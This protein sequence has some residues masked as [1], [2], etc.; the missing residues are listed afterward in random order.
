MSLPNYSGAG[1]DTDDLSGWRDSLQPGIGAKYGAIRGFL[2]Q[3]EGVIRPNTVQHTVGFFRPVLMPVEKTKR[4]L[5]S[6]AF[7][8]EM[9][10]ATRIKGQVREG[11]VRLCRKYHCITL[12]TQYVHA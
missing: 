5:T 9:S 3:T 7:P 6:R 4:T 11:S 8:P 12:R 1:L 2:C 10:S